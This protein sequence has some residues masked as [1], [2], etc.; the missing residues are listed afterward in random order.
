MLTDVLKLLPRH[1]RWT[2]TAIAVVTWILIVV[3]LF[4]ATGEPTQGDGHFYLN[5]H[6]SLIPVSHAHYVSERLRLQRI[7]SL[8]AAWFFGAS[9]IFN[10]V[11]L[12]TPDAFRSQLD[13]PG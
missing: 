13:Q 7:F 4:G 11:A 9:F 5:S 6:G 10:W 2:Y 12:R 8:T 3:L 1:A